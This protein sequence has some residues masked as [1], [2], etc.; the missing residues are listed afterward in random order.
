[1]AQMLVT[2]MPDTSMMP[3]MIATTGLTGI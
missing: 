1:V 2:R 3:V